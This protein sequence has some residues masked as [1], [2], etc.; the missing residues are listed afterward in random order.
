V[1]GLACPP[2]WDQKGNGDEK[3]SCPLRFA[4]WVRCPWRIAARAPQCRLS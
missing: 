1:L 2:P 3:G 4:R